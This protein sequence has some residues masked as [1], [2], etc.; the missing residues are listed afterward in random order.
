VTLRG[1]K[2]GT[3]QNNADA[4]FVGFSPVLATSVWIGQA[5]GQVPMPGM[6][7]GSLPAAMFSDFVSPLLGNLD[8]VPFP[9]VDFSGLVDG[10]VPDG[11]DVE[12]QGTQPDDDPTPAP[13]P[14]P[15]PAPAPALAPEP[16][17]EPAPPPPPEPPAE[18]AAP[19]PEDAD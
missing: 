5:E 10:P 9:E 13:A 2:T 12:T 3:T 7:G 14:P 4:W 11:P 18:D 16:A 1:G 17:P 8:P 19:P 6:T 15:A